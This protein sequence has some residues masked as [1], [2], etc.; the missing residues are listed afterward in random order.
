ML[1][2]A[3]HPL[4]QSS[5]AKLEGATRPT[6]VAEV[7]AIA[8]I[9]DVPIWALFGVGEE[10]ESIELYMKRSRMVGEIK[11]IDVEKSILQKQ[12]AALDE[13][14]DAVEAERRHLSREVSLREDEQLERA[15]RYW[16]QQ[17]EAKQRN[18][19]DE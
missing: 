4:S 17:R 19:E 11:R 15:K 5:V 1:A 9:F 14:R 16:R 3:G 13:R 2:Q 12:I 7:A 8:A 6:S 10:G 18:P